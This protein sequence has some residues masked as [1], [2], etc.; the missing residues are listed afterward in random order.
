MEAEIDITLI[1]GTPKNTLPPNSTVSESW[2]FSSKRAHFTIQWWVADF[3]L[4]R[5]LG[6]EFWVSFSIEKKIVFTR[7]FAENVS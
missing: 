2:W 5:V 7:V 4:E 1:S 3:R 6:I